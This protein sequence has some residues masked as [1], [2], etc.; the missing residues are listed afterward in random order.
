MAFDRQGFKNELL[1]K[2][3]DWDDQQIDDYIALRKSGA[4]LRQ[5]IVSTSPVSSNAS[6]NYLDSSRKDPF[7][8]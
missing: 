5:E 2:G 7:L 8:P 6:G 4:D 1:S 3:V